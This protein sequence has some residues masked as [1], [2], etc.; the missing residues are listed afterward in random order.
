MKGKEKVLGEVGLQFIAYN[1]TRCVFIMGLIELCKK[2][3]ERKLHDFKAILEAFLSD[4][5][6]IFASGSQNSFKTTRK[7]RSCMA[8]KIN[9]SNY[10]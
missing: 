9:Y 4:L 7:Y 5:K 1:L 6:A 8:L 3:K 2:L 10:I